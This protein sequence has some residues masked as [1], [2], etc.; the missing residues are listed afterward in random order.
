MRTTPVPAPSVVQPL[1]PK[2]AQKV[3]KPAPDSPQS[4]RTE[5]GRR[6]ETDTAAYDDFSWM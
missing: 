3:R 1:P 4:Q 6:S 2:D 5:P